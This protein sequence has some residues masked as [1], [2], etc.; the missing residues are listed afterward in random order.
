MAVGDF[1]GGLLAGI[2]GV[3]AFAQQQRDNAARDRQLDQ[4]DRACVLK[5]ADSIKQREARGPRKAVERR[6]QD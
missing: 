2:Q 1:G 4:A 3:Q 6:E 5:E